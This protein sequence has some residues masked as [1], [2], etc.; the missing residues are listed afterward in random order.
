M[1]FFFFILTFSVPSEQRSRSTEPPT[2]A[3]VVSHSSF[4][5]PHSQPV[6]LI[7][8]RNSNLRHHHWACHWTLCEGGNGTETHSAS[9][10][11][12]REKN[13]Q[14]HC[15][16]SRHYRQLHPVHQSTVLPSKEE[17]RRR[18]ERTITR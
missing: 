13:R 15:V 18:K 16:L 10:R 9:I 8:S 17:Q 12:S 2:Q 11:R 3:T 14:G 1:L 5:M 4:L 6:A 7:S